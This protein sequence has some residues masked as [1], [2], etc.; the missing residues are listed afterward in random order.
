MTFFD[1]FL[2]AAMVVLLLQSAISLHGPIW[3]RFPL[4]VLTVF[5]LL[6]GIVCAATRLGYLTL[7]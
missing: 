7:T 5:A 3:F 4:R 6:T 2:A 1:I